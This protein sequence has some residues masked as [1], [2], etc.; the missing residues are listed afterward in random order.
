MIVPVSAPASHAPRQRSRPESTAVALKVA[1]HDRTYVEHR[2][3]GTVWERLGAVHWLY[4]RGLGF[5][6]AL[7]RLGVSANALTYASLVLAALA[8]LL[9]AFSLFG[10][11]ALAVLLS[12]T[13]D[14]LDGAVARVTHTSSRYG[15][16]LDSTID[17]FSDGLPLLGLIA[18][19]SAEPWLPVLPGGA[20]LASLV[21]P[22]VRAR[23]EG[24]G[25]SL[26]PLFMRR[27]ERVAL[28]IV[29]L[30]LGEL[31]F[32]SMRAPLLLMGLAGM[33]LLSLA[34]A[35]SALRTARQ[36]LS[37]DSSPFTPGAV[38]TR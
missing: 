28:L 23:A 8:G 16:L 6:L 4:G 38:A 18:A 14:V 17:R 22:Y 35:L 7:G 19:F 12:G 25:G 37:S 3:Q 13:C 9:S 24:L 2:L 21:V 27:G 11:A 32:G 15:A 29:S 20:L 26:P 36:R 34:G 33:T 31:R 1:T 10:W 30:A 5:A